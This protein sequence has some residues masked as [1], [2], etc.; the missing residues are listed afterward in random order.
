[1]KGSNSTE[2]T[3]ILNYPR[4]RTDVNSQVVEGEMVVLDRQHEVIHFAFGQPIV[5]N[6]VYA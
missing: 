6:R 2:Y 1:M 3:S 4:R 5:Y